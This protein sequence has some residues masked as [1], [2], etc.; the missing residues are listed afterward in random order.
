[1]LRC[2]GKEL[3]GRRIAEF[4]LG[5]LFAFLVL[6]F[7]ALTKL[8]VT[9]VDLIQDLMSA[10]GILPEGVG[11]LANGKYWALVLKNTTP[12]IW[13]MLGLSLCIFWVQR[14]K[15]TIGEIVLFMI[16]TV[17]FLLLLFSPP[18]SD[19]HFLPVI[20]F[21]Y[22]FAVVGSALAGDLVTN[23]NEQVRGWLMP[24]LIA[25]CL[26]SCFI[27]FVHGLR[28]FVAFNR[29]DRRDML[30]WMD[31]NLESGSQVIADRATLLSSLLAET[32]QKLHFELFR[33]E[34]QSVADSGP[35]LAEFITSGVNY[36]ALSDADYERFFSRVASVAQA[37]DPSFSAAKQFYSDVFSRGILIWR[38]NRGAVKYM[39]P[40][41]SV[42]RLPTPEPA[43]GDIQ[44]GDMEGRN[45]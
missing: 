29:D 35:S 19:L 1:V 24:A 34:I 8:P 10:M 3:R 18:E 25:L 6:N 5:F 38:R 21:T 26:A 32:N 36:A 27:E 45:R 4:I 30:T 37:N 12:A 2:G 39:Q 20:G 15:L 17:Y 40:G 33:G 9:V 7:S 13:V 14:R 41:L 31:G 44:Q 28:Y 42:Y 22:A 43:M 11:N 23:L 16:P